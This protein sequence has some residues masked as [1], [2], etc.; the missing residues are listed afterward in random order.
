MQVQ[1]QHKTF[2]RCIH[3][4][5]HDVEDITTISVKMVTSSIGE[6]LSYGGKMVRGHS[7]VVSPH[8]PPSL[9]KIPGSH[10]Q[11]RPKP[12]FSYEL[13]TSIY[14]SLSSCIFGCFAP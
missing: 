10:M 2:T 4:H 8:S 6:L 9:E 13:E 5:T 11:G 12:K 1:A 14:F 3:A 7:L